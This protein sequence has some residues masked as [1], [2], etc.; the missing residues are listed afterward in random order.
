MQ[1]ASTE[2]STRLLK[3]PT[4]LTKPFASNNHI[5]KKASLSVTDAKI[6]LNQMLANVLI[7]IL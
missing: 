3:H 5:E 1:G 2:D 6:S 4:S 7:T